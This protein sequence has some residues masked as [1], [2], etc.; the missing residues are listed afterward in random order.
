MKSI[1]RTLTINPLNILFQGSLEIPTK[2]KLPVEKN[3]TYGVMERF[4][5]SSK[6]KQVE[7][8]CLRFEI[9]VFL[10]N[11]AEGI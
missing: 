11:E 8:F 4:E 6:Q 7:A 2:P 3:M 9:K 10:K 1:V 5:K